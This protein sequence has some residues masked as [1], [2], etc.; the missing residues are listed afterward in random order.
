MD[1]LK[2]AADSMSGS[3]NNANTAGG[4]AQPADGTAAPAQQKDYG[5]KIA[6]QLF[7]RSG[8][9]NKVSESNR[10]KITDFA[11]EQYEKQ[12]GKKVDP[13]YSN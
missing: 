6:D 3:H 8:Y 9:G 5:D 2:K 13:K 12:T 4:A 1:F 11:R 7:N 10:E